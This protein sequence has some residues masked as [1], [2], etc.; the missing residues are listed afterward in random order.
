M[1]LA[2]CQL[3]DII[4]DS[5]NTS[6]P[7]R[8]P[9]SYSKVWWTE[10]LTNLRKEMA[11]EKRQ[12]KQ[13]KTVTKWERFTTSRNIYYHAIRTAKD[14]SWTS[15]LAEAA[16]KDVF[17]AYK[18]TKPRKVEKLPPITIENQEKAI[19]FDNKCEAFIKAMFPPPP[20]VRLSETTENNNNTSW[21]EMTEKE[22]KQAIN[23]SSAR[24]APGPDRI[25]FLIIQKAYQIIPE[26][27]HMIYKILIAEG[28]HLK[29]WR[30]GTG[31]I[32]KKPGKPDYSLPKAY[33]MITLLN[34]LGKV[35]EKIMA[36]RLSHLGETTNLLYKEQM[37]GRKKR[38]AVDAVLALVHDAEEAI[39]NN[40]IFSCLLLDV[41]GAFDH[42]ALNQLL[43][44][45]RELHLP[46]PIMT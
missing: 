21:P 6:I 38:S 24:K 19:S 27:F 29:C 45:L 5:T 35:A 16:G 36:T 40:K 10:N 1:E 26:I 9:S 42:V 17:L 3:R 2:A 39:N 30:Q 20:I 23:T 32:L 41:K 18:F 46:E 25:S 44:I 43:K 11:R 34:C 7:R 4:L 28:Y 33:R 8:K 31:V 15:F 37:G 12:W 14:K 22:V 13:H